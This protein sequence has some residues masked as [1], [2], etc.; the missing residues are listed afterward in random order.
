M[1]LID[2][3]I[4]IYSL[5]ND[6][7]VKHH[8]QEYASLPKAISVISYGEFYFGA[9][10]SKYAEK[11]LATVR[12]IAEIFPVIEITKGI[13]E[14]FGEL[15]ALLQKQGKSISDL[16]LIIA[17]TALSFNYILVTINEKHFKM[18]PELKFENWTKRK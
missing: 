3:D 12:Q 10:K 18:V 1:Y 16:D 8:F 7:V 17:A 15:K 6:P 5:K 14:T 13:M 4:L 9:K 11:N 2:S